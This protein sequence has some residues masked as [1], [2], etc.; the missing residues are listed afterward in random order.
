MTSKITKT[1]RFG[2]KNEPTLPLQFLEN[3]HYF[4]FPNETFKTSDPFLSN[5]EIEHNLAIFL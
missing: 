4:Q 2:F 5:T 3:Q 1:E